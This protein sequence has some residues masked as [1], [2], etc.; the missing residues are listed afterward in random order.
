M[1]VDY[2][3]K[4]MHYLFIKKILT[5]VKLVELFFKKIASKYKILNNIIIDRNNLLISVFWSE[6]YFHIK[7]KW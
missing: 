6:I 3:M 1:I 4:M 7:M 2:Y 5:I